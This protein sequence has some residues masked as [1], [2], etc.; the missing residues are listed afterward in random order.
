[1]F[2]TPSITDTLTYAILNE[3]SPHI[4]E[5]LRPSTTDET[6]LFIRDAPRIPDEYES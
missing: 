2:D 1:M 3:T 6:V 5:S 4:A